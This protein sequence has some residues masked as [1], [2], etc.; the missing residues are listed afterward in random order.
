MVSV[1]LIAMD[2]STRD[3]SSLERV[4]SIPQDID[5][6]SLDKLL[7]LP[8]IIRHGLREYEFRQ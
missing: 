7:L 3:L 2:L 4:L 1:C 8:D 6:E 5:L